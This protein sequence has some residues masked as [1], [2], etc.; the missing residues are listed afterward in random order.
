M[1]GCKIQKLDAYMYMYNLQSLSFHHRGHHLLYNKD[2]T[3]SDVRLIITEFKYQ[4][5]LPNSILNVKLLNRWYT[6]KTQN[7]L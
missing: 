3:C 2:T 7:Y 4:S 6:I 1:N 5:H